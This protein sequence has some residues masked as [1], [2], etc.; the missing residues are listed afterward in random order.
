MAS[1]R[2]NRNTRTK[3]DVKQS[4]EDVRAETMTVK[5]ATPTERA[6]QAQRETEIRNATNEVTVEK[7]VKNL[8]DVGLTLQKT[9]AGVSE[10]FANT[11]KEL[12]E[13]REAVKLEKAEL[14]RL[15][16]IDIAKASIE[17]LVAEYDTK[18]KELETTFLARREELDQQL[19]ALK[20]R[21][22]ELDEE[23]RQE[24]TREEAEYA[25]QL[26]QQRRQ[27]EDAWKEQM[28]VQQAQE[29]DR[30]DA[31]N[32]NMKERETVMAA[33][34]QEFAALKKTVDEMPSV[35]AK[36]EKTVE[37]ITTN[38]LTK[39]FNHQ[40][41]MIKK[42]AEVALKVSSNEIA[43]LTKTINEQQKLIDSLRTQID[44]ANMRAETIASK[45]LESASGQQALAVAMQTASQQNNG[46]GNGKRA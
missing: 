4:F 9:L 21:I 29:R 46:M 5:T 39:D 32:K 41:E 31:F 14:E 6:L 35:I 11:V 12:E 44:A 45:A 26:G 24:R 2:S 17:T 3:A 16:K 1:K 30:A 34:E 20:K 18:Q 40:I 23:E 15:Y 19:A 22:T 8:T 13:T 42:D 33:K 25:Y 43:S 28:R 36:A 7:A 37:A 10:Q 38:R 27:A